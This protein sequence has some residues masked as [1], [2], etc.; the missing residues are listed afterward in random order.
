MSSVI[1]DNPF[2][3]LP[4]QPPAPPAP[5][6]SPA[7]PA[8]PAP[9]APP[10]AVAATPELRAFGDPS[11]TRRLI[12]DNVL[13]AA[14]GFQPL[15]NQRYTLA[16]QDVH[17][18][19]PDEDSI[20]RRKRAILTGDTLGRRLRGTWVL[21]D[22]ATGQPVAK[23]KTLLATIPHMTSGGTFVLRGNEYTMANQLRLRPGVFTRVKENGELE[24]HVNVL[25]GKGVSHRLFL[26]PTSG[27]F[28][29]QLGQAQIPLLPVLRAMGVTD[30]QL[31][32]AW[33]N[34]L[35]AVNMEK[36]DPKAIGKL[37][38]KL[39]RYGDP[40]VSEEQKRQA[41]AAAFEKMEL[42][43]DVTQQTLKFP[44]AR[45][46]AETLL[47][48]TKK[49]LAVS[50]GEDEPDERDHLAFQTIHGPEDIIAERLA[51]AQSVA[52]RLLWKATARGNL[53]HVTAGTFDE[54][55]RSAI[56]GS[57][58]AQANEEINPAELL[59]AQGRVTRMGVGGIP[60]LDAV[61]EDSRAVQPSQFGF[62]DFLRTAESEKAG[63][64]MRI[65]RGARKGRD[66]RMYIQVRDR[67]GRLVWKSAQ[68]LATA[69]VA[70]PGEL[71]R[72]N[73]DGA[74]R[75][76]TTT[77]VAAISSGRLRMVPREEVTY[78]IPTM[79]DT[80]SPLGNM[81]PMKSMVKGQRAVMAARMLTQALPLIGAE[82]PL[83]QSGMPGETDR[84]FE[85]EYASHLGA[86]RASQP[87]R[88]VNVADG[89]LTVQYADGKREDLELYDNFPYARKTFVHQTPVVKPGDTFQAGQ[90]LARSN[91]T[92]DRGTA[93]LGRNLRVAYLPFRG[94]N[95]E[96]ANV[97]SES[98]AKKLT[99]EHMYQHGVEW[100]PTHKRGRN[101]FVSLFPAVYSRKTL[102][103]FDEHGVI[104]P[105]TTVRKG[106][107]LVLV[108][109]ERE[110][111][112]RS[113]H[114]GRS[115]S[116]VNETVTWDHPH[117]GVV[118]DVV[119]TDKRVVVVVRSQAPMEV[120]DKLCYSADTEVLTVRGW[121][122]VAEVRPT[123][124]IASLTPEGLL[125]YLHPVACH[126]YPYA[127]RM[128]SL[129]TT[130][131]DLCVTENHYLYA[132]PR[133]T[134]QDNRFR[135]IRAD[136][137]FGRRYRLRNNAVWH[138]ESPQ[139]VSIP[140]PVV[141]CGR[142]GTGRRVVPALKLPLRTYL[143]LLGAFV[144]E[145][146]VVNRPRNRKRAGWIRRVYIHQAKPGGR[147]RML[148]ELVPAL[149]AAGV[150]Y[151]VRGDCLI[152]SNV[153]LADYFSQFGHCHEKHLPP[154]VFNLAADD[155]RVL[156]D[157]LMWGDGH[158]GPTSW[159][160]TTTS[161]QLADDFQR[162][163]L[164]VGEAA[165]V[166]TTPARLGQVRGQEYQLR[167]RYDIF[168]YRHKHQ[169]EINHG[170][171]KRQNG[172]R[173]QWVHYEGYVYCVTLPRNHVLYVRRN[174][175]P[176]WCGNSGRY[177]DKGLISAII[178][179]DEMPRDAAGRPYE[180]L[181]NPL[182][183]ISRVNPAQIVETAL[184]KIA[185][186]TGK[187]YKLKDFDQIDDAVEFAM[188][189]LR[190][191]GLTDL[192]D[193]EDA[194]TG[195]KIRNVLTG[196]RF[197]MKL[198]QTADDYGQGRGLG[199]Y[200]ADETPAK[201][202]KEGSKKIGMLELNSILSHGGVEVLRDA[203]LVRGQ[204]NPDWWR[205]F[206]SGHKPPTPRVPRV[207]EKFVHDLKA[208]GINV[209]REG[210][211][212][213]I[214]ALTDRDIDTLAGAREL[215]NVETVDWRQGLKPIAGGLFDEALTG[216]HNGN[217]WAKITLHEPLPNPVM[218]EP[219]RWVL[220]LTK[221]QLED[222]I[223][224]KRELR[225]MTGPRA[226]Q[227]ALA[228]MNLDREIAQAAAE[229]H[230]AKKSKR[231]AAARRWGYLKDAKRVGIHPRD[232]VLSAVPVLPPAFRPISVIGGSNGMPLVADPNYLY[233]E[234][235]EANQLLK[236]M[237]EQLGEDV[238]D[239]RLA[240]YNAFRGVTGLG[241]PIHPKNRERKVK[242]IL[243]H[244]FSS[245]PKLGT[246]QQRL[247]G[248]TTDVV[249]RA[250]ISPNPDLDMDQVG[251]PEDRAWDV[252][253][254]FIVRHLVRR[255]VPRLQAA[256][257][258]EE[259]SSL[260]REA[261]L[262]EMEARPV[263]INRAPT[264]HRYG[265]MAFWPTITKHNVLQVSPL[266]VKGFAA[267][268]DGDS[269]QYHVPVSDEAAKE[270][271]EKML[272]SQNL[273]NVADFKVL[274]QPANE[275]TGGLY[276]ASARVDTKNKPRVFATVADAIRAYKRG[277]ID[278]D[279]RVEILDPT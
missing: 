270:A 84:S 125:E 188:A 88:V 109:R 41:I 49:L 1:D 218:E 24:A 190:K 79:E 54:T 227:Q 52:R 5:P 265:V 134:R 77:H 78:E 132:L 72:A 183:I 237:S 38:A 30:S 169:P 221:Q 130:Q 107:P 189:E 263:V 241:D 140:G 214:M 29:I 240:L 115:A 268:F 9:P 22:N 150:G 197:F 15:A 243:R 245:S 195:R 229:F 124:E 159:V 112:H 7:S 135:L 203:K 36:N 131:V 250:V 33:G 11:A 68:D 37:Y 67:E 275:Y 176:V 101:A 61:P 31:R 108:V 103:N 99:S 257:A 93:A 258:V 179:D 69:T 76:P 252:Y 255:G 269:M 231:D 278:V 114:R 145:G 141:R 55:I 219:I 81:I 90:L 121:V 26:D 262:A 175:K 10:A 116:F 25:P 170:H 209:V 62:I 27:V 98:A 172:Q 154:W 248:T 17:Y 82:A 3:E 260:A 83:V 226:I 235:F 28:R 92:D 8:S 272:P 128:Y 196:N 216:G 110:R 174:G 35:T 224:G 178:P 59:D 152:I 161:R 42:D 274:H 271:A 97:I 153:N 247:L 95:F 234:V 21:Q 230:G 64:D 73:G 66:G 160:Y 89:K 208:A 180:A 225:G 266:I 206:M 156:Q 143:M 276:E 165:R 254:P 40:N 2:D 207:Y 261:L 58:L 233:K 16:L 12:Y 139:E 74:N 44:A 202:G 201:G 102:E 126:A 181:I 211:R 147:R 87:G 60:S 187:P 171:A 232:W 215:R 122:P 104:R 239:E 249:G 277:E 71:G 96:D 18:A 75:R 182:G 244:V 236:Q 50:R 32:E 222:V 184:G 100:E 220:G 144:S 118:T 149:Q 136:A 48:T 157:W 39:V 129:Q 238:G 151:N 267:D 264:L 246:V 142:N 6:A 120:G 194:A 113:V 56:I 138:G 63:V 259:R 94:L 251:L 57:G 192:E 186:K 91:F 127:G 146:S 212:T 217:R 47:A 23:K 273:L 223:A 177:G 163:C 105:G 133:S 167:E 193:V 137:L 164:H 148:E 166:Q 20:A 85:E 198:K 45:V 46:N 43:P 253:R 210:A 51:R 199:G 117:P 123:D 80:F 228:T 111:D 65:A 162:L 205:Q 279:R 213:H 34:D 86:V 155:L 13:K 191:H 4:L 242:G 173:E 119:P 168:V 14:Q 53:D 204:A 106:D 200:T 70:F 185:E 19:D 158:R 256:R